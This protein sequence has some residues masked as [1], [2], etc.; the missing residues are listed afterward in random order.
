[1]RLKS[2]Q[3]FRNP[4]MDGLKELFYRIDDFCQWFEP[5]WHQRLLGEEVQQRQRQRLLSF[6]EIMTI[7]VGFHQQRY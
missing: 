6:C 1:M 7:L 3:Q 5:R 2:V 4:S